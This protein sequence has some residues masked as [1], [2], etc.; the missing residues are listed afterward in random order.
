MQ[1]E[2]ARTFIL[3]KLENELLPYLTYHNRAH[4]ESVFIHAGELARASEI[5]KIEGE[6]L[7]ILLTAALFH[8]TGFLRTYQGHE[9]ASCVIARESLRDFG[10]TTEQTEKVCRLIMA[11]RMPQRPQTHSQE[12]I[13]DAD[14][15]Y[16]GTGDYG[17]IAESL[18][19][20]L[21]HT[22][23]CKSREEWAEEQIIFLQ[24]HRYWTAT[25]IERLAKKQQ[26]N[27]ESLTHKTDET[28]R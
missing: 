14:L 16:L 27:L 26:K 19:Q 11:T 15:Y 13:C 24:T 12:I 28:K 7:D 6:D 20:E 22:G 23:V 18:Y 2:A 3:H 5:G 21:L 25:A 4:T 10:Y 1:T 8:D 17:A 9:E